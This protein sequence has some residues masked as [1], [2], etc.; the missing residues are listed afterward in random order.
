D[1]GGDGLPRG[2]G[3]R[4]SALGRRLRLRRGRLGRGGLGGRR[5]GGRRL[6]GSG[7]GGRLGGRLARGSRRRL[8][9]GRG[10][11]GGL[12]NGGSR[13]EHV[14]GTLTR[15]RARRDQRPDSSPETCA[16]RHHFRPFLRGAPRFTISTAASLYATAPA[17]DSSYEMTVCPKLGA[18]DTRTERGMTV[19]STSLGK[20]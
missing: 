6:R 7:L 14:G 1:G 12:G 15:L 4:G 10:G 2:G 9:L 20:C 8:G 3:L 13:E 19:F 16:L 17:D 5:L 18:S 11:R